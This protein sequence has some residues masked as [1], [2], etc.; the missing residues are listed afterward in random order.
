MVQAWGPPTLGSPS[1]DSQTWPLPKV[2]LYGDSLLHFWA[3]LNART[4]FLCQSPV[5]Y[6]FNT[7][8]YPKVPCKNDSRKQRGVGGAGYVKCSQA[9]MSVSFLAEHLPRSPHEDAGIER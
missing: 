8:L 7:L 3:T 6:I 4:L 1:K 9:S 5:P 2:S